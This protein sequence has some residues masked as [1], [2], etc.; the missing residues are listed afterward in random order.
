[1]PRADA[2][3]SPEWRER[4]GRE[5]RAASALDHPNV[6][7]VYEA[8]AAG[9]VCYIASAYCPGPTLAG[10]LKE[11]SE[12][13]PFRVAALLVA[14]LADGVEHAH[15][16]GVLHRD[17]KPSNVLLSPAPEAADELGFTPRVTDFGLAKLLAEAVP[18]AQTRSGAILGTVEYMA[19]E[20]AAGKGK[21]VG[22]AADV[23]ALGAILD[24]LLTGRPPLRGETDLDTL[25]Q[26]QT[27]E[28]LPPT[29]LRPKVPR[30]L[31]TVCL[32]CLQKEPARRY[33]GAGALAE[34]L[35]RFLADEPIA[36]RPTAAW[37][38]AWRWF[39]RRPTA[40]ALLLT[41]AV[42]ILALVGAGVGLVANARLK[43]SNAQLGKTIQDVEEEL[44]KANTPLR[45]VPFTSFPGRESGP[46]FS[47]DGNR[48]AFSWDGGQTSGSHIYVKSIHDAEG[49]IQLTKD[50]GSDVQ[51]SWSPDGQ[52]IAFLRIRENKVSLHA[53]PALPGAGPEQ[54]LLDDLGRAGE[55]LPVL[56]DGSENAGTDFAAGRFIRRWRPG[57]FP[58]R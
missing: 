8:G 56:H 55:D 9:P 46:T 35:R 21:A 50:L 26:V 39:R 42:A 38:R 51:P 14:A 19:P 34:D 2:L 53:V 7:P 1:V 36:A 33:A 44:G 24:E 47:P 40:A 29:R 28:P 17:L 54:L 30:D 12:P 52:Q 57:H 6:V 20:Q 3:L 13:V 49:V 11:R 27:E 15:R 22:P 23:Y 37:E 4:F 18:D 16:R 32:K 43:V 48:L 10:W 41:G 31:E 25:L 45:P 58:R 5:A